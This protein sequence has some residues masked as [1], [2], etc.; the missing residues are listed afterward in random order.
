MQLA[1]AT[2]GLIYMHDRGIVHGN[3]N[4][5]RIHALLSSPVRG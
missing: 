5:V 3:L 2:K 1:D 4:G